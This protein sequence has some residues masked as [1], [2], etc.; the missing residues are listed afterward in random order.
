MAETASNGGGGKKRPPADTPP[1]APKPKREF[2]APRGKI[3]IGPEFF[4]PLPPE[5]L[6]PWCQ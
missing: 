4:G 6:D 3:S 5:E 2:G 1:A